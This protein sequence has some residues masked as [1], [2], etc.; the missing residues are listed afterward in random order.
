MDEERRIFF[1]VLAQHTGEA[2]NYA[3]RSPTVRRA[4]GYRKWFTGEYEFLSLRPTPTGARRG[5][6][7]DWIRTES[8]NIEYWQPGGNLFLHLR[9]PGGEGGAL[10]IVVFLKPPTS[11]PP[12]RRVL[13][14]IMRGPFAGWRV[15]SGGVGLSRW[16]TTGVCCGLLSAVWDLWSCLPSICRRC[17]CPIFVRSHPPVDEQ[18][19]CLLH[20]LRPFCGGC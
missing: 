4:R 6:W 19:R 5:K 14:K 9:A 3:W 13:W 17:V 15:W 11:P 20:L 2:T 16:A 12:S 18:G 10:L 8:P 7:T 1:S